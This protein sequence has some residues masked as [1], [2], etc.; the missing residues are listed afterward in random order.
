MNFTTDE[1][2]LEPMGKKAVSHV[3]LLTVHQELGCNPYCLPQNTASSDRI[4]IRK[5]PKVYI[6]VSISKG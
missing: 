2:Y 6:S 1:I 5:I 4:Q 3:I